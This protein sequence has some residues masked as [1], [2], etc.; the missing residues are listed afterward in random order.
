MLQ[1]CTRSTM[2]ATCGRKNCLEPSE[3]YQANMP[4]FGSSVVILTVVLPSA[5]FFCHTQHEL[6]VQI[7]SG[8]RT[9]KWEYICAR[10][11]GTN[12]A[13]SMSRRAPAPGRVAYHAT[14]V[15]PS[16]SPL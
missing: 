6:G 15:A 8:S 9:G 13:Q 5:G 12:E 16:R 7:S 2:N 10:H 4:S 14:C 3:P 1:T 11:R